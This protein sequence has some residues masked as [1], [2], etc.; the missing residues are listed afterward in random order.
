M[1]IRYYKG[2]PNTYVIAYRGGRVAHEGAGLSFFYSPLTT[3][4]VA[5]PVVT[6]DVPFIFNETTANFQDVAVQ[7]HLTYRLE[8]PTR[9]AALLDFSLDL[10]TGSYAT[11]DPEKLH[12]RIVHAVQMHARAGISALQLEEALVQAQRLATETLAKL[13]TEDA[14]AELGVVIE[15]LYLTS[16]AATPE[17]KKAL[18]ADYREGLQRRA[19]QAIYARRAA[20][21]AEERKIRQ[22]EMD[23]D[24]GLEQRRQELVDLQA[25]N[26]LTLAE[27]DAKADE[28][29]L[30][31][32]AELPPQALLGLALKE[33]AAQ[34][35]AIGQLNI[36]PD[37]LS[38]LAG[39]MTREA[40]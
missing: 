36:T 6:Q 9:V 17:M 27:A 10:H 29:K 12:Q 8:D 1:L 38:Q 11:D 4:L 37:L 5:V 13:R 18:E 20:A 39:W 26:N 22:S 32:Y 3:S 16:I 21:V 15:S 19:D 40:S 25:Q 34:P 35:S 30:N 24:I 23:T 2:M 14:L 7:G 28:M 33:W 31:P